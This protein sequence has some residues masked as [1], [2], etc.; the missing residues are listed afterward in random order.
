MIKRFAHRL[1]RI[2]ARHRLPAAIGLVVTITGL[3]TILSV[4]LY[5]T[6]GTSG[7]DLSRPG[8]DAARKEVK[9]D[10][11]PNFAL[12]GPLDNEAYGVFKKLYDDQ[13]SR[14]SGIGKFDDTVLS[15]ESLGLA[16]ASDNQ[17][18]Q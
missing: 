18:T 2:V 10:S 8:Y 5:I 11:T 17:V 15:D 6:S 9:N 12:S 7:L 4:G 1:A 14:L 13:R 16:P 3:M